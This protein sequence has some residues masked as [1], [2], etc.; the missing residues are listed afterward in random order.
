MAPTTAETQYAIKV[1]DRG[2]ATGWSDNVQAEEPGEN[3]VIRSRKDAEETAASIARRYE[4]MGAPEIAVQVEVM[5]RTRT[6]SY[7][8]WASVTASE[9]LHAQVAAEAAPF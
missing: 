6:C 7:S 9:A 4:A 3:Q 8:D 1:G 2:W 5:Q